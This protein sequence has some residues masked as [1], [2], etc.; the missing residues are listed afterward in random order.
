MAH[1]ETVKKQQ[2]TCV[3]CRKQADKAGLFRLVRTEEG[4]VAYDPSGKQKGRGAY[5]CCV[6][7]IEH[8]YKTKRI[9]KALRA[10]LSRQDYERIA[11]SLSERPSDSLLDAAQTT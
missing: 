8:A 9:E 7:C 10:P 6:A 2:R 5:V 11:D 1:S 4:N 3:A